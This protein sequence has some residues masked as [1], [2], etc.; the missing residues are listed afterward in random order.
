[1]NFDNLLRYDRAASLLNSSVAMRDAGEHR[2]AL[3]T[4]QQALQLF[5]ELAESDPEY[6]PFVEKA[7]HNLGIVLDQVGEFE[8]AT[9]CY[10]RAIAIC[11]SLISAEPN[12]IHTDMSMSLNNLGLVYYEMDRYDE[13]RAALEE[14]L[15]I[16]E[17]LV[18]H[19]PE[20]HLP[21]LAATLSHL[22]MLLAATGDHER[23]LVMQ[24]RSLS[25][26]RRLEER[27]PG[28]YL[29]DQAVDLGDLG[30]LFVSMG[31][32]EEARNAFGEAI[33][34]REQLV[35]SEPGV[36]AV[37]LATVYA[38]MGRLCSSCGDLQGA[39]QYSGSAL[40]LVRGLR[41][42]GTRHERGK[43]GAI[44]TD[45]GHVLQQLKQF[46]ES[47][48]LCNE[49]L[50][51]FEEL[52]SAEP[53]RHQASLAN[54]YN[55]MSLVL[56]ETRNFQE[57]LS[58]NSKALCLYRQLAAG[59]PDRRSLG[60]A[61]VLR[62][63]GIIHSAAG[64]YDRAV[65]AAREA[66]A[67][68]QEIA[69]PR[70][71]ERDPEVAADATALANALVCADEPKEACSC[72]ELALAIRRRLL[73]ERD[74][75]SAFHLADVLNSYGSALHIGGEDA[76]AKEALQEAARLFEQL[77]EADAETYSHDLAA[78]LNNLGN[79]LDRLDIEDEAISVSQRAI[80]VSERV[81]G[82]RRDLYIAKGQGP[83]AYA[84]WL[85][86]CVSNHDDDGA[87]RCMAAL[88]E[89]NA[90]VFGPE[91]ESGLGPAAKAL[92]SLEA[93]LGRR[94]TVIAV[95]S[96]PNGESCIAQ[97]DSE[98][99]FFRILPADGLRTAAECL[100]CEIL[101]TFSDLQGS[102]LAR[103][104][105]FCAAASRTW[106]ALPEQVR[107]TLLPRSGGEVLIS[108]D[109]YWSAFP[110]EALQFDSSNTCWLGLYRPLT[111][112]RMISGRGLG[113]LKTSSDGGNGASASVVCPWDAVEGAEL[114]NSRT[115]ADAVSARLLELGYRLIPDGKP[116]IGSEARAD[117]L[118]QTIE[119]APSI[120]HYTGHGAIADNEEVLVL[121]GRE[122][123]TQ[124]GR[125]ELLGLAQRDPGSKMFSG[126]SLI[127]L[128]SCRSGRQRSYGGQGE[129][130]A[131]AMLEEGAS[132]VIASAVPVF[133]RVGRL[134]SEFLY[135]PALHT[136]GEMG[137]GFLE[138][139]AL[140]ERVLRASESPVWPTWTLLSYHGN[141]HI[142]LHG[143][144]PQ[145]ESALGVNEHPA[146]RGLLRRVT[147]L[148]GCQGTAKGTELMRSILSDRERVVA[149][150]SALR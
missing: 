92:R 15:A 81:Y 109:A 47:L 101:S 61:M 150:D 110:W 83:G 88:R 104:N 56:G 63:E 34:I 11:R 98:R 10:L 50:A 7:V 138:A 82:S 107:E 13:A 84:R 45:L 97:V 112:W 103:H 32:P 114:G 38:N 133:D 87:F 35:R 113:R 23:S 126:T 44:L 76:R 27:N 14:A 143:L 5:E 132:A 48:K 59:R 20:A 8:A 64:Q 80:E 37:P 75:R 125:R 53:R 77:S 55:V 99:T 52:D 30:L 57:A 105:R 74:E 65:A 124:F 100:F 116:L 118:R 18:S 21:R 85:K 128:N 39:R 141:P 1:M 51:V 123:P 40:R 135:C 79:V 72:Y 106:Q 49:A 94:I 127:V 19:S 36:Y 102:F 93:R 147:Q 149:G 108:G 16:R 2:G 33:Q 67:I 4:N 86:H 115:E 136:I 129:D 12:E 139:R 148:L 66:I 111:R 70:G 68:R 90:L 134:F 43:L 145:K 60:V 9:K 130:L 78:A 31:R 71:V 58:A 121:S 137:Q 17:A 26:R 28:K 69:G 25:I 29:G 54:C 119:S 24:K 62:N 122:G 142:A 22:G 6:L 41:Q 96:L 120:L 89:P 131:F 3:S 117:A 73:D 140:L 144:H 42:A 91:G 46:E 95:E 146:L